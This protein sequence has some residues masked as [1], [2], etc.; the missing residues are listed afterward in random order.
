MEDS[1][2]DS[3]AQ[4]FLVKCEVTNKLYKLEDMVEF[5]GRVVSAE[6]KGILFRELMLGQVNNA[7][8]LVRPSFWRRL[9]CSTLD[10][11]ILWVF[12]F[13][14][15]SWILDALNI[16]YI[17]FISKRLPVNAAE[18][19]AN[20]FVAVTYFFIMHAHF[21][22]TL[23]KMAGGYRVINMDGTKIT[24]SAAAARSFWYAGIGALNCFSY[25]FRYSESVILGLSYIVSMYSLANCI[26]LVADF[27]YNRPIHDRMAGTRVVLDNQTTLVA[28]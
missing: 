28:P 27:R 3:E 23:G 14:V 21:G 13:F 9:L 2:R 8:Y 22:K 11:A 7:L 20:V 24:T 12:S 25:Y 10:S 15:I 5:R 26:T 16:R 4:E 17:Y 19:V 6:G 18:V 1:V